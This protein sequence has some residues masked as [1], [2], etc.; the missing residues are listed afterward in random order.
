MTFSRRARTPP[1][2]RSSVR[3]AHGA[4]QRLRG[5]DPAFAGVAPGPAAQ[6]VEQ[7]L[8]AGIEAEKAQHVVPLYRQQRRGAADQ[9]VVAHAAIGQRH[10]APRRNAHAGA[11]RQPPPEDDGVEQVALQ[12]MCVG[13]EP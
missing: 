1:A 6:E 8:A 7:R 4:R 13:T 12:P 3:R 11:G 10:R 2:A 5:F 9:L